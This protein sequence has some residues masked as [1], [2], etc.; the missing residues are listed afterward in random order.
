MCFY[1]PGKSPD[2]E[3]LHNDGKEHDNVRN[4][5]KE[6]AM[7]IG[8]DRKSQGYGEPAPESAPSK[9]ADRIFFKASIVL[10]EADGQRDRY[11]TGKQDDKDRG[12]AQPEKRRSEGDDEHFEA[13][14]EEENGIQQVIDQAPEFV[15]IVTR[16]GAHGG[17]AGF[18]T[19]DDTGDDHSKGAAD[20]E[21][22]GEE[23]SAHDEGQGDHDLDLVVVDGPE[24]QEADGLLEATA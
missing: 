2:G 4:D 24:Q 3:A 20:P 5:D 19:G 8:R 17:E 7:H 12:Q 11:I 22:V 9:N 23:V 18:V 10:Q 6:V 13:D 1:F 16:D 21:L 15:N 14:Q